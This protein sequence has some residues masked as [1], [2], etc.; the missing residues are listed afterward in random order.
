[1]KVKHP[2][3]AIALAV[4]VVLVGLAVL[5]AS[6]VGNDPQF[7]GGKLLGKPMPA[8]DLPATN[9]R[10]TVHSADLRG[11]VVLVNFWNSWCIPCRQEH[12]SLKAFYARHRNEADFEMIGIVRDDTPS[13]AREWVR[14]NRDG[15]TFVTDPHGRAALVFGTTGQP[16][17]YMIAANG[18]VIGVQRSRVT[19]A[20]LEEMLSV[21]R[22]VA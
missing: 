5:L 18:V 19:L 4:G 10:A 20:N 21:A 22:S 12:P 16:E 6:Q 3:R 17:S 14:A 11:K 15:W 13:A 7:K 9:G 2:A 1:M 8:F